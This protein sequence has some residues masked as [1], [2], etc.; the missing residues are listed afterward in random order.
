[1]YFS[2]FGVLKSG[3]CTLDCLMYFWLLAVLRLF[4]VLLIVWCTAIVWCTSAC[5]T[6]FR[7]SDVLQLVWCSEEWLMYFGLFDVLLIV[8]CTSACLV[9]WRV[10]DVL[11]IVWCTSACLVCW[12][13]VDVLW[14]VW[15]TS[16]C[17]MYFSL[18]GVL[19]SGWC[20]LDCLMCFSLFFKYFSLLKILQSYTEP[21]I[22]VIIVIQTHHGGFYRLQY[23]VL[24]CR[25]LLVR[26]HHRART[27]LYW[28]LK[29]SDSESG[30]RFSQSTFNAQLVGRSGAEGGSFKKDRL[31]PVYTV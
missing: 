20:T 18:F 11:W 25:S 9:C 28:K 23:S 3:W 30:T 15:C 27:E 19:K 6:Y 22:D 13:V 16:D 1:M 2:L 26:N 10:V 29:R 8:W 4:D 17:L 21:K 7:L 12:R 31:G 14:I 24:H 5:F